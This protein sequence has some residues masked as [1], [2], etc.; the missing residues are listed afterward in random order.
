MG[1]L[2]CI[3]SLIFCHI[4]NKTITIHRDRPP[5]D[6]KGISMKSVL[7]VLETRYNHFVSCQIFSIFLRVR[8]KSFT[9]FDIDQNRYNSVYLLS[10]VAD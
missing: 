9:L 10:L 1:V 7:G 3:F 4:V 2:F 8:L 6:G 5:A